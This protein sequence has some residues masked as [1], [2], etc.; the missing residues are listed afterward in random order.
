MHHPLMPCATIDSKKHDMQHVCCTTELHVS[1]A[2]EDGMHKVGCLPRYVFAETPRHGQAHTKGKTTVN[3]QGVHLTAF[4]HHEAAQHIKEM[5]MS[6]G[7][8]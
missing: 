3:L 5:W 6:R 7:L 8:Q 1:S 4:K 2:T